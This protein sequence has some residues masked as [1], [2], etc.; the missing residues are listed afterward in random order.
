MNLRSYQSEAV[1]TALRLIETKEI[2][3][4]ASLMPTGTG[5]SN[6]LAS[7]LYESLYN[8][9]VHKILICVPSIAV[10]NQLLE[11]FSEIRVND[12]TH[13]LSEIYQIEVVSKL[14]KDALLDSNDTSVN[15]ATIQRIRQK[16]ELIAT[17][18]LIVLFETSLNIEQIPE[19][20]GRGT[21]VFFLGNSMPSSMDRFFG[22]PIFQYSLEQ[23]FSDGYLQLPEIYSLNTFKKNE[24]VSIKGLEKVL[25]HIFEN[26]DDHRKVLIVCKNGDDA[27]RVYELIQN[28]QNLTN[29][30]GINLLTA[31]TTNLNSEIRRFK[32][33]RKPQ[34]T[35]SVKTLYHGYDIPGVT[36]IILL[37]Y[38][39]SSRELI[40]A[41]KFALRLHH[42]KQKKV[43]WDLY[44]NSGLTKLFG[45]PITAFTKEYNSDNNTN[46]TK[47][48]SS[49]NTADIIEKLFQSNKL[50]KPNGDSV[51]NDDYL[52]RDYVVNTLKGLVEHS[53]E[54]VQY[55]PFV[56]GLFGKWGTGKSTII[57]L[58]K[59]KFSNNT[60]FKFIEYNAWR[61]EHC[62]NIT[63]SIANTIT[64]TLYEKR[65]LFSRIMLAFK[66]QVLQKK[67]TITVSIFMLSVLALI[68]V[69][70]MDTSKIPLLKNS[71]V[72]GV[73]DDYKYLLSFVAFITATTWSF[74]KLPFT[75]K[76]KK[77]AEKPG[78]SQYLG[79]SEEIRGQVN[80]L[81]DACTSIN[82]FWLK[83]YK[84]EQYVLIIDDLDRCDHKSILQALEAV[85]V[86]SERPDM[87]V[88]ICVDKT[89]L[90]NS[91]IRKYQESEIK[92]EE[93]SHVTARNFLAKIFQLSYELIDDQGA[94]V[95]KFIGKRIY[96]VT[97]KINSN[98]RVKD[99]AT[100]T[101]KEE[102]FE[103]DNVEYEDDSTESASGNKSQALSKITPNEFVEPAP[104]EKEEFIKCAELFE[105]N[106][107]RTLIRLHNT[108]TLIKGMYSEKVNT[109]ANFPHLIFATF[110][111]EYLCS[112]SINQYTNAKI[113]KESEASKYIESA[114]IDL[115]SQDFREI[116]A[117]VSKASLPSESPIVP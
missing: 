41:T 32:N 99:L 27:Q 67:D 90:L 85:R 38:F 43:I 30:N 97:V 45:E 46:Y 60:K 39:S 111:F 83:E 6:V 2:P 69:T 94:T 55:K 35:I 20:T 76:I 86:L 89:V 14:N 93:D 16:P 115:K 24:P 116:M 108:I 11:A 106:N 63:A 91:V 5:K 37:K 57:N 42:T 95:N 8:E 61:N 88:I 29:F 87:I 52:N 47:T 73:L 13:S 79:V 53:S 21:P 15:L 59:Q 23:A 3:L 9:L 84:P 98:K 56:F 68:V 22:E 51:S 58:L 50:I 64:D 26:F 110:F 1:N 70:F 7:I 48:E 109:T 54:S 31:K 17:Y 65:N 75:S 107:P 96:P 25:P 19:L 104:G 66:S 80:A 112:N 81:F 113:L 82:W 44:S 114:K 105:F 71:F 100:E 92:Q 4:F 34:I 74:F 33:E 40:D 102:V 49:E 72:S 28:D 10:E 18:D 36:D 12:S 78:F 117:I 103:E 77:L 62:L 101:I